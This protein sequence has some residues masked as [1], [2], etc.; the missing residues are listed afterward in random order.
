MPMS[1]QPLKYLYLALLVL[2]VSF[3][4]ALAYKAGSVGFIYNQCKITLEQSENLQQLQQSYCGAFTEG[5]FAGALNSGWIM[6]KDPPKDDPCYEDKNRENLRINNRYCSALTIKHHT[7]INPALML[8]RLSE[9]IEHWI[10][11]NA[12]KSNNVMKKPLIS[13]LNTLFSSGPFCN[14]L[15]KHT[16]LERTIPRLNP[17]LQ[18][19]GNIKDI[20]KIKKNFTLAVKYKECV[21]DINA[22]GND[23]KK[24]QATRCGAEIMGFMT[25]LYSTAHLQQNREQPSKS[26]KKQIDR[27][28]RSLNVTEGMCVKPEL[29]PLAIAR[30][31]IDKYESLDSKKVKKISGLKKS[32][33]PGSIGFFL[34]SNRLFCGL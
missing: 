9:V 6:L 4:P 21:A 26:C 23:P 12:N 24:F 17:A 34:S 1:K 13:E 7:D 14:E 29:E 33:M 15:K 31:F 28:Y 16:V 32:T 5:Y 25:G 20:A 10:S 22:A 8:S 3:S 2:C 27:L 30:A 18:N 11:F 19:I